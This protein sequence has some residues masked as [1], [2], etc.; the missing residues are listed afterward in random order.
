MELTLQTEKMK[1]WILYCNL[2][3]FKNMQKCN[4]FTAINTYNVKKNII[5]NIY[6]DTYTKYGQALKKSLV[7]I[8]QIPCYFIGGKNQLS[9]M[10]V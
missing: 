4:T 10:F 9:F 1:W 5:P 7:A 3:I 8:K 2:K 6:L